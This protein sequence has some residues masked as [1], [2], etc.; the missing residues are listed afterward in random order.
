MTST[1]AA[2]ALATLLAVLAVSAGVIVAAMTVGRHEHLQQQHHYLPAGEIR[3]GIH[4]LP[5]GKR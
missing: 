5:G 4:V 3:S 2:A 1:R